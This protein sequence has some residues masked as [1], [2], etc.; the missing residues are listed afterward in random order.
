MQLSSAA[1]DLPISHS[2]LLTLAELA[3]LLSRSPQ[4]LRVSISA[5]TEF[6]AALRRAKVKMG[7]RIYFKRTLIYQ[8][9]DDSTGR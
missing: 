1:V 8:L 9:I 2:P 5:N 6:G 7:R 3:K 4:G